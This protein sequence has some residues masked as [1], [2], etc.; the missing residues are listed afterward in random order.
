MVLIYFFSV[1]GQSQNTV[2]SVTFWNW[3]EITNLYFVH[4]QLHGIETTNDFLTVFSCS[5]FVYFFFRLRDRT[6]LN[7]VP[8]HVLLN[9]FSYLNVRSL[10][11]SS[12]VSFIEKSWNNVL[13]QAC[14]R[15]FYHISRIKES[16]ENTICIII[17]RV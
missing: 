4:V 16:K 13:Y 2:T 15:V 6:D 3:A 1:Y 14:E 5:G 12:R 17:S 11:Q 7:C 10:C 9:I 8:D